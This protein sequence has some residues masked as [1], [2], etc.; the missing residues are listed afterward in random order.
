MAFTG[1]LVTFILAE[2]EQGVTLC[3]NMVVNVAKMHV[4][5]FRGKCDVAQYQ[6]VWRYLL[7]AH[8]LVQTCVSKKKRTSQ[9]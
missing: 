6:V 7:P 3:I 5:A 1:R 8:G 4:V 2:G 9:C